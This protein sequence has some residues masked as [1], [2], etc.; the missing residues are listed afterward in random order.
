[1]GKCHAE[2]A[3]KPIEFDLSFTGLETAPY[4]SREQDCA[5]THSE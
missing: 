5:S 2:T 4:R 3:E 1:M